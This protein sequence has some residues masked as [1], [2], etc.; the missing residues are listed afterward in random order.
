MLLLFS[1]SLAAAQTLPT[2]VQRSVNAQALAFTRHPCAG[3]YTARKPK[4]APEG[5][6]QYVS[7]LLDDT[8]RQI[9]KERPE[10]QFRSD[11]NGRDLYRAEFITSQEHTFIVMYW[12][13]GKA[14]L[15]SC[16]LR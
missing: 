4:E 12:L 16:A 8:W 6:F 15:Y 10:V 7:T 14:Y 2:A 13:K 3:K 1:L 11:N 5:R 9:Q